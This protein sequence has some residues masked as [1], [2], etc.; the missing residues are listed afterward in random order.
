MSADVRPLRAVEPPGEAP[1]RQKFVAGNYAKVLA[2]AEPYATGGAQLYVFLDGH[3]RPDERHLQ[4]RI[5]E[6]L[7]EDWDK[8]RAEEIVAYL[9]ITSPELWPRPPIDTI[10]VANGL[11]HLKT[12]EL[13]PHTPA[14]LSPV[15]V[16]AAYDPAAACPA[17][18][19][20]RPPRFRAPAR[21]GRPSGGRR[22]RRL[23]AGRARPQVRERGRHGRESWHPD[24][25][26]IQPRR[27]YPQT[28]C[29]PRA[30]RGPSRG[31]RIE[32]Q[33]PH[34]RSLKRPSTPHTPPTRE[35]HRTLQ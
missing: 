33:Q 5:V 10:N 4:Q 28:R 21:H 15:Q 35:P 34:P 16:A 23:P 30:H 14:H 32:L 3:Y 8:R 19:A 26:E 1:T 17:I 6:L 12:R 25:L 24:R 11:L 9:R 22:A 18:D 27:T 7:G 2:G 20:F 13:R 29:L 31:T